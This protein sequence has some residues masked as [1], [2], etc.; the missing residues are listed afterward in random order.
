MNILHVIPGLTWERGG[1]TAVVKALAHHQ[2]RAGHRIT[3]LSTDQGARNGEHPVELSPGVTVIR[4]KVYGPDRLAYTLGFARLVRSH[5]AH[6]DI[7]HAHSIFTYPIHVALR[8]ARNGGKPLV[9]R[10][11]GLLHP[12]SLGLSPWTKRVYLAL[13]GRRARQAC[14]AWHYTSANE[15]RECWPWDES[16]RF[17]VPNGVEPSEY[18]TDRAQARE[19]VWQTV[20]ALQRSPYVLFLGRLHAKKRLDVLLE[21]FLSGAPEP[22]KLVVAGPDGDGLWDTLSARWLHDKRTPDRVVRLGTVTGRAKV[23][24]LAGAS[25]FA[26]PSE[27]ENFGVAALEALATGTPLLLSPHVDFAEA[28]FDAGLGQT[29]PVEVAAWRERLDALLANSTALE[30]MTRGAPDWVREHYAWSRIATDLVDRYQWVIRGC[31]AEEPAEL[32]E[33][34]GVL[35]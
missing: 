20:P 9:L 1:P 22:Y 4:L 16:P 10:P 14:S 15:A 26:L 34:S 35:S 17:M 33:K 8:E 5:L 11:C 25:L 31:P 21:A 29:A 18:S 2:S 23:S 13:W 7:I 32:S 24:L 19:E 27:H 3:V 12:Y 6:A 28:A 30:A